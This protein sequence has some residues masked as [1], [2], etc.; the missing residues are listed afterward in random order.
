MDNNILEQYSVLVDRAVKI[1]EKACSEGLFNV[2]NDISA[3]K[4]KV[5]SVFDY[6]MVLVISG[7][8]EEKIDGVLTTLI[9]MEKDTELRKLKY[10]EKYA[11]MAIRNGESVLAL[12]SYLKLLAE[13]LGII[14]P[15][16]TSKILPLKLDV[17]SDEKHT[18]LLALPGIVEIRQVIKV[19]EGKETQWLNEKLHKLHEELDKI[20]NIRYLLK[21]KMVCLK[22]ASSY[23][24]RP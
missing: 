3:E 21:K 24:Q 12:Q 14:P 22:T 18:L 17:F 13:M 20:S 9:N 8:D 19:E 5:L 16:D 6:G 1:T 15:C 7:E 4:I 2:E 10:L 11:V 23:L